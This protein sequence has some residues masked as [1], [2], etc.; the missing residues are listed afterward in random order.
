MRPSF[1]VP[2]AFKRR[3]LSDGRSGQLNGRDWSAKLSRRLALRNVRYP[4]LMENLRVLLSA[5]HRYSF[6][7]CI[8]ARSFRLGKWT[9]HQLSPYLP[10]ITYKR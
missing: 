9:T 1:S 6:F 3:P 7:T 10:D 8:V 5:C 2:A 4:D